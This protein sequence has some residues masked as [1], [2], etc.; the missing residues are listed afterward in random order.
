MIARSL[1]EALAPTPA[2][3]LWASGEHVGALPAHLE[4]VAGAL[5]VVVPNTAPT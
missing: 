1:V 3:D 2:V 4:P 5:A